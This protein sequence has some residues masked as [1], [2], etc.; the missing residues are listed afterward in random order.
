VASRPCF[1]SNY[2]ALYKRYAIGTNTFDPA[3]VEKIPLAWIQGKFFDYKLATPFAPHR[4][5]IYLA[6]LDYHLRPPA[7]HIVKAYDRYAI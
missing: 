2:A 3:V 6:S 4:H 1:G 7:R 5:L